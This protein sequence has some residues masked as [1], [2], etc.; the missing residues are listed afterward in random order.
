MKITIRN[1]N[2]KDYRAVEELTREA[3]WNLYVPGCGEH[4]VLHNLFDATLPPR[5]KAE[6]DS[7]KEFKLLASLRY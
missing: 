6:T 1:E 4:F 2:E 5:E 3:Y 7:Q